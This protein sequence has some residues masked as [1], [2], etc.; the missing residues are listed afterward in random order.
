MVSLDLGR[1]YLRSYPILFKAASLEQVNHLFADMAEE[2]LGE[3]GA[4]GA[5]GGELVI[6]KSADVRYRGQYHELEVDL[7]AGEISRPD[8]EAA[9][10]EFH[11]RH[12][13]LFTFDLPKVPLLLRNLRLIARLPRPKPDLPRLEA[14][15][16][17]AGAA[18]KG[19]RPGYFD[20]AFLATPV[21]DGAR[22]LAGNVLPGPALVEAPESTLVIPPG[23]VCRVDPFGNHIITKGG[24]A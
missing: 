15:E 12:K 9:E 20:G 7:P 22:L 16:A 10:R 21:Y 11:A 14:G 8:L 19:E 3:L 2:A 23:A 1:D 13:E 24:A 18:L 4:P 17:D 5:E 6:T